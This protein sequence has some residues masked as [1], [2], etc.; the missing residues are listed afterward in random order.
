MRDDRDIQ[1]IGGGSRRDRRRLSA[2]ANGEGK[3]A[4]GPAL[5]SPDRQIAAVGLVC[6]TGGTE[7]QEQTA[8]RWWCTGPAITETVLLAR[9]ATYILIARG[10]SRQ[11]IGIIPSIRG[12]WSWN[13]SPRRS[14]LRCRTIH[15]W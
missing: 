3:V 12:P 5:E 2:C 14:W 6:H 4:R 8:P 13:R 7:W 1:R 15:S 11:G 10:V 9:L